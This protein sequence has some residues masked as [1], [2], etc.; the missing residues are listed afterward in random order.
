MFSPELTCSAQAI[1]DGSDGPPCLLVKLRHDVDPLAALSPAV[2][3]LIANS[4]QLLLSKIS[5]IAFSGESAYQ[6]AFSQLQSH[7]GTLSSGRRSIKQCYHR[8]RLV[9]AWGGISFCTGVSLLK[10]LQ[11][12]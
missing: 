10:H 8:K 4:S 3:L 2:R 7:A 5:V 11:Q 9:W 1:V 6:A 12:D